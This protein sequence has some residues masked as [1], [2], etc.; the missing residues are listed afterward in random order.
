[1]F[2]DA[3][4]VVTM[5]LMTRHVVIA[6]L[7]VALLLPGCKRQGGPPAN[8]L[9]LGFF[10]TVTHEVALVMLG[11]GQLQ[12]A[13]AP[14]TLEPKPFNAGPE[15][16]EALL[17]GALDA[18]YVGS[19]PAV[20]AYLRSKGEALV[21]IAGAA[22]H[23]AAFVVGKDSGI[24][25]PESLHGKKL[26]DPQLGNTQDITLKMW[27]R[28]HGLKTR[29]RGGDVQ[30]MPMGSSEIVQLIRTGQLDGAWVPEPTVSRIVHE[31]GARILVD[32]KTEWPEGLYPT[33]VL[34]V[35]R[36]LAE[37]HP[38]RVQALVKAHIDA[39]KWIRAH[40]DEARALTSK[41]ILEWGKKQLP[42]EVVND[43]WSRVTPEY[44]L[45]TAGLERVLKDGRELGVM[46]T[47]GDLAGATDDRFLKAAGAP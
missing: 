21:V 38:E 34:V 22:Q 9:R 20:N 29:E 10:P 7:L 24:T 14:V 17:A 42:P 1:M 45:P 46:P 23:G 8:A 5:K 16:M 47:T 3:Q 33:T 43:A 35:T 26:A 4:F 6:T 19:V 31:A 25:G 15:A 37:Q 2:L 11:R 13:L 30:V 27:L 12:Q 28:A 40:N 41:G 32:E 36:A 44:A 18:C 39:V